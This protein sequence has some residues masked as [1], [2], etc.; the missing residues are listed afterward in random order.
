MQRWGRA[1]LARWREHSVTQR[2]SLWSFVAR[3]EYSV[4]VW[5]WFFLFFFFSVLCHFTMETQIPHQTISLLLWDV[6]CHQ[7]ALLSLLCLISWNGTTPW[8]SDCNHCLNPL[9]NILSFIFFMTGADIKEFGTRM[10]GPPLIPMIH[11]IEA[12]N[13][14][15]VAAIEGIALGGGLELALG[16]HYRVAHSK[17]SSWFRSQQPCPSVVLHV[18]ESVRSLNC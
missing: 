9:D 10:S 8:H 17:V 3:M 5:T 4:G 12:A 16:C 2:W 14:P 1:S 18:I 13:K 11:A 15:M 7:C 6:K